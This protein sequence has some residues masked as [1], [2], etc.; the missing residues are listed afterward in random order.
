MD[1]LELLAASIK[2]RAARL[3]SA[4]ALPAGRRG[5]PASPLGPCARHRPASGALSAVRARAAP[6][7]REPPEDR[8]ASGPRQCGRGHCRRERPHFSHHVCSSPDT[9]LA[10][11]LPA[12]AKATVPLGPTEVAPPPGPDRCLGSTSV[13]M[14]SSSGQSLKHPGPAESLASSTPRGTSAAA[15]VGSHDV[16]DEGRQGRGRP[17]AGSSFHRRSGRRLTKQLL[18]QRLWSEDLC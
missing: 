17:P 1:N 13:L 6:I 3:R 12:V 7:R 15:P 2:P 8:S 10:S 11:L 9:A 14:P 18:Q 4:G 5:G 16:T